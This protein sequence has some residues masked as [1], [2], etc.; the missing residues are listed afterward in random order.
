MPLVKKKELHFCP[1]NRSA[2]GAELRTQTV[3]RDGYISLSC[4]E[5]WGGGW[6][7]DS[8]P[9][10]GLEEPYNLMRFLLPGRV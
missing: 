1:R 5:G 9:H 8:G 7:N 3:W 2:E 6:K 4:R 10:T